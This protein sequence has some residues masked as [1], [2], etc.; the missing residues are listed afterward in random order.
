MEILKV[1]KVL[2]LSAWYPHRNDKMAGL[3]VQKHAEAV[4]LYCDVKL[5]YVHA[6]EKIS[7][8]EIII[9]KSKNLTEIIVYYPVYK[10]SIF[11]K[12]SKIIN[13]LKAYLIGFKS[14]KSENFKPDIVHVN[15]LTRTGVIALLIKL[16]TGIPYVITEH[17][18]RYLPDRNAFKGFFRILFTKIVVRNASAIMP[19]S[20]MLKNAML[21]H[22]L[23]NK[24]YRIVDNVIDPSFTTTF[25]LHKRTKKRIILVT[26]FLEV[27]KNVRGIVRTISMISKIRDDFELIIIGDGLNFNDIL[28]YSN[29]LSITDKFIFFKGEKESRE[30][31]EWIYNSD[32]LVLFSNYETA[33][34]VIT[35]SLALGKPVLSTRVGIAEDYIGE[36]EGIIIEIG[37]EEALFEKLNYML[38]NLKKYDKDIIRSRFINRFSYES[39][40]NKIVN[41]YKEVLGNK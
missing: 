35:E 22:K 28:K 37:D 34:I 17:W 36:N 33:G 3:F 27:A 38:D 9:N 2:F 41:C 11:Y 5:I 13:Y 24:N 6:D 23:V 39:V 1:M 32:F 20:K 15:V 31:A 19:V 8:F 7:N 21:S 26:C 14:L 18:T 40:G 12:I 30:V 16:L 29:E 25:D 4:A 10:N